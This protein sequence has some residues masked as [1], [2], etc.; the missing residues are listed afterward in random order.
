MAARRRCARGVLAP[1]SA[2]TTRPQELFRRYAQGRSAPRPLL[3]YGSRMS[4]LWLARLCLLVPVLLLACQRSSAHAERAVASST[5][6]TAPLLSAA[7]SASSE[8]IVGRRVD[9]NVGEHGFIPS[10]VDVKKGEATTLVFTRTS[11]ST[12][13]FE[14]VFPELN[15]KKDLPLKR[16]VAVAVPVDEARTIAFQCGMGMYKSK[17]VVQ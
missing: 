12:C 1:C 17:V 13:A 8:S 5:P 7:G 2:G 9:I 4:P 14:V 6:A 3:G 11:N 15:L 10:A 16:P